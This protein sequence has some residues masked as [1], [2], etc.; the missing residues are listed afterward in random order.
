MIRYHL[1]WIRL[2]AVNVWIWTGF[3][4]VILIHQSSFHQCVAELYYCLEAQHAKLMNHSVGILFQLFLLR[5]VTQ[6]LYQ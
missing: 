4:Q 1:G 5:L 2:F 6:N 3:Q